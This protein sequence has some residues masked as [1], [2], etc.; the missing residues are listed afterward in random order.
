MAWK[1]TRVG[2]ERRRFIEGCLE[3][4]SGWGMSQVCAAFGIS[5]KTSYKWLGTFGQRVLRD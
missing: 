4:R 5:R 3:K 2:D 1:E